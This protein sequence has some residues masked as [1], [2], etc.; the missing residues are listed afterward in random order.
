VVI[1]VEAMLIRLFFPSKMELPRDR[2]GCMPA[3]LN[4]IQPRANIE[5]LAN[6]NPGS[7]AR[8]P[9]LAPNLADYSTL[10]TS[11]RRRHLSFNVQ[12]S[13]TDQT[14]GGSTTSRRQRS[15]MRSRGRQSSR[16][17]VFSLTYMPNGTS[18]WTCNTS[19]GR[20]K[21]GARNA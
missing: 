6:V 9:V 20:G 11:K 7:S 12:I 13:A 16:R 5:G 8:E 21:L 10:T 15:S 2:A 14:P 4:R 19:N 18:V 17:C 1:L 3:R